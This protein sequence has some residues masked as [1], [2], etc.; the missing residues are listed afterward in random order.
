MNLNQ[1]WVFYNVAKCKSFSKAAEQLFLTQPAISTQVKRF[2]VFY[3]VKLFERFAR[4]IQLTDQG[5][6]L[7]AHAT[8]IF[9]LVQEVENALGD[10]KGLK[11]GS[12]KVDA[13]RTLGSYYLPD[14]LCAFGA[15]YPN[16]RIQMQVLNTHD[17]ME[18]ILT[19]QSDLG[20]VGRREQN[21]K[22][23]YIPFIEDELVIILSPKHE[24]A[25]RKS[26]ALS[27]LNGQ[28]FILREM[29]SG[30]REE[31]E[32]L[33]HGQHVAVNVVMELGSNEAIKRAVEKGL[34]ASIISAN[35]VKRELQAGL[36]KAIRL[37]GESATRNFY[38]IHH[39]DK[40]ISNILSY[41]LQTVADYVRT[42]PPRSRA[43]SK[44]RLR[45]L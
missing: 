35:A 41:F 23:T 20:F 34:G 15:K 45:K 30:T 4:T 36:L 16:V 6:A 31:V 13:S 3:N 9:D 11:G 24:I 26:S 37:P 39:K 8:K 22:L 32:Q 2:E 29:G 27:A 38:V 43:L 14:V 17:V 33:L 40:Y 44:R 25:R 12:L 1:L 42:Y 18:N 10:M 21:D 19:F 7:Y 5:R 28:P